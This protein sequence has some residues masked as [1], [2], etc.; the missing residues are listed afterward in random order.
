LYPIMSFIR[1]PPSSKFLLPV[2][3]GIASMSAPGVA[4]AG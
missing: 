2:Q 4:D 3:S 1:D